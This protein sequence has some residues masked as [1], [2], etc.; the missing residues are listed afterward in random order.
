MDAEKVK[1]YIFAKQTKLIAEDV[2][3]KEQKDAFEQCKI[4]IRG[5]AKY[6]FFSTYCYNI[7]N[8]YNKVLKEA[9]FKIETCPN[10]ACIIKW[11]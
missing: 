9:E 5:A 8:K 4:K 6:G 11:K 1:L 10:G 2:N 3:E 7:N